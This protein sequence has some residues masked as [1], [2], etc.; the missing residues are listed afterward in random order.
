MRAS[1]SYFRFLSHF[2]AQLLIVIYNCRF[3]RSL[4]TTNG[5]EL[6]RPPDEMVSW[7]LI[8]VNV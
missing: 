7:R 1:F 3:G 8:R 2:I 5:E 6:R 4:P